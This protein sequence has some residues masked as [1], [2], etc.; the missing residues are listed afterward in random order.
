[1]NHYRRPVLRIV[2]EVHRVGAAAPMHNVLAVQ[3]VLRRLPYCASSTVVEHAVLLVCFSKTAGQRVVTLP[4]CA[5]LIHVFFLLD[6]F[7]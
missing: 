6:Y 2:E 1:M 3:R 4:C 7:R 5:V